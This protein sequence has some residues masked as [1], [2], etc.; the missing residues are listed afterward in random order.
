MIF[1]RMVWRAMAERRQ[2]VALT[3]SALTITSA[4]ATALLNLY[5]D[6]E[7]KLRGEF[8]GYG[9]NLVIAPG[10]ERQ[11]LPLD[12]LAVAEKYGEAAPF[13]YSVET[14]NGEPVVLAGVD[15]QRAEPL[16]G[17]WEITGRRRPLSGECLAGERVAARFHLQPGSTLNIRTRLGD[18]RRRVAG[19]VSTG[20]GE[21]SQVF[22]AF[23]EAAS[24]TGLPRQASLIR[25]RAPGE[26]ADQARAALAAALP[27]A[28][29]RLLRAVVESE[30]AVVLKIRGTLF[31]LTVL[32]L[33]IAALCVMNNFS[34]I[35]HQRR[36]EIGILKALGGADRPIAALV[37]S[38]ALGIG[39]AGSVAGFALG[40]VLARWLGWRIFHQP[41][42]AHVVV[43]PAVAGI[44]L[45]VALAGIV[46]PLRRIR[47][48]EPAVILRGE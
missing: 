13:L 32:I 20:A 42:A 17:Y 22:L 4:L 47:R 26:K 12:A 31:L 18:E 36:K 21:D 35:V 15:F 24:A 9:A 37:A 6:I 11:T 10:A 44:T 27:E 34:A 7:G 28:E 8:H 14:V 3:L 46:A 29:V 40:C 5:S 30:A 23:E 19:I 1:W 33:A 16:T 48:I 39:A 43:L 38:E 41:V 2:R 25:V 45:T